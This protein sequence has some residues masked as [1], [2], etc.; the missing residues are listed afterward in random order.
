LLCCFSLCCYCCC[1]S[2][3]PL[4]DAKKE[5][6]G[7]KGDNKVAQSPRDLVEDKKEEPNT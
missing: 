4:E 5:L 3:T 1:K 7:V 6:E 2:K